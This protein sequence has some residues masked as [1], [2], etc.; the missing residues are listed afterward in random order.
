MKIYVDTSA[1]YAFVDENDTKH[2]S[3][4]KMWTELLDQ[5]VELICS[6]YVLVETI[7][8]LHHRLGI[9]AVRAFQE[10]V[11][12][13]LNIDWVTQDVHAVA[14]STLLVAA[15]RQ[16]S[17]VD[18][19]SFECMWRLDIHTAFAYDPHFSEQG[20]DSIPA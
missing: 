10:K 6:N 7:A 12:P 2:A 11:M 9:Q 3:A 5:G 14:V 1:F 20:F 8:L 19:T 18:C 16:L 4:A 15:R 13:I 17:L